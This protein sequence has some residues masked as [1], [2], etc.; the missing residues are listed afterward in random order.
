MDLGSVLGIRPGVTAVIGSGGKTTLLRVLGQEL[1]REGPVL[2][3]TTTKMLPYPDLPWAKT[4]AELDDLSRRHRLLCAGAP[5]PGTEKLSAP[6]ELFAR[7]SER[8]A[9]ILTEADGAARRPMKAHASW[10]PVVPPEAG[11][12]ICVVGACGFGCPIETAAHRPERFADLAGVPVEVDI[13]P[14]LAAAV[15]TREGL[16]DGYFIN[17]AEGE[18]QGPALRLGELL[19]RPAVVGSLQKGEYQ[20]CSW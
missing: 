16:A 12:T 15:L 14:E 4:A 3:C 17:Q 1:S 18:R 19:H 20:R 2:L 10:E 6:T 11:Q 9:Y 7:L 5:V 8:F 13:T